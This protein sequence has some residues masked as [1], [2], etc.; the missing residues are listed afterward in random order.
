MNF[1]TNSLDGFKFLSSA[2][3]DELLRASAQNILD[4]YAHPWDI[5]SESLQNAVDAI[6]LNQK[7]DK[8]AVKQ[9]KIIF[10]CKTRSI[11]ISDTGVGI[12]QAQIAEI[13][14]PGM[15]L[16]LGITG[17]RGEKSVGM[18]F[19]V[20]ACN[21]F[22]IE[23]C[24]GN[25]TVYVEVHN[26]NKWI[27]DT[28]CP[29]PS[30][31]NVKVT[32]RQTFL[33]SP[34]Y[35]R[36]WIED[37]AQKENSEEDLFQYTKP[38]LIHILR[39]KTAV[40]HTYPL[41]NNGKRPSIDIRVELQ[42]VDN[43]GVKSSSEQIEYA[44]ASPAEYLPKG[45]VITWEKYQ[46]LQNKGKTRK[47]PGKSLVRSGIS[48]S[49]TGR[50]IRWFVFA[51]SRKLYDA[52]SERHQLKTLKD[53]DVESGIFVSTK[54][55]PTGIQLTPPRSAQA[56]YWPSFF[57]LLEYDAIRWDVGRKFVGGRVAGMLKKVSL[58]EVFNKLVDH[59][60]QFISGVSSEIEGLETEKELD[61]IKSE[62]KLTQ[63]LIF[64]KILYGKEPKEEQ[65][66]IAIFHK[67]LGAGIL[68]GYHTLRSAAREKY[69]SMIRYSISKSTLE[70]KARE[71]LPSET[72]E[73]EIFVEF[74][75]EA[76]RLLPDLEERKRARDIKLL[77]CWTIDKAK[78]EA[79]NIDVDDLES[80]ESIFNGATHRLVFSN[81]YQFGADNQLDVICLQDFIR[82]FLTD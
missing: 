26:A 54:G 67:L 52:I 8:G 53:N 50:E 60:P 55:M 80:D 47:L 32:D 9:M 3:N 21:T 14:A 6:E 48:Q 20:F 39:S 30:F 40:G 23:T 51:A 35:T 78:F 44:Y 24:D 7:N 17:M 22:R 65:G 58:T 46:E 12:S 71:R 61:E 59:I 5:L 66:V 37:V 2:V 15:S 25:Q 68:K 38:R 62:V 10:D 4:S 19:L 13:L 57:I 36:V 75:Y 73:Y 81:R 56:S 41:F 11:E 28:T 16:K 82:K 76:S 77:I 45:N 29:Q 34:S 31:S 63:D 64:P 18:S 74:K 27:R 43:D 49:E 69:D 79:E 70:G 42:Y 72:A 33:G 1:S